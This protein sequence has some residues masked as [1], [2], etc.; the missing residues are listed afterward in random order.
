MQIKTFKRL[1]TCLELLHSDQDGEVLA[2]ARQVSKI[3][4]E[5]KL[6]FADIVKIVIDEPHPEIKTPDLNGWTQQWTS[7]PPENSYQSA[8]QNGFYQQ[9]TNNIHN[10]Y[11]IH[12]YNQQRFSKQECSPQDLY[13]RFVQEIQK[14]ENAKRGWFGFTDDKR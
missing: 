14:K 2:A 10:E 8:H 4:K 6:S 12:M 3:I 9:A 5:N 13:A 11:Y 1:V 7:P